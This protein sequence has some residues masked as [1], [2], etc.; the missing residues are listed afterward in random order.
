MKFNEAEDKVQNIK[1]K[2]YQKS[3]GYN[4]E[5]H[6]IAI[7]RYDNLSICMMAPGT[8]GDFKHL[9]TLVN[10]GVNQTSWCIRIYN[11]NNKWTAQIAPNSLANSIDINMSEILNKFKSEVDISSTLHTGII[12]SIDKNNV[13][14]TILKL[15]EIFRDKKLHIDNFEINKKFTLKNN[16]KI[17]KLEYSD[18]K[19]N[20][21]DTIKKYLNIYKTLKEKK[22]DDP[23]LNEMDITI[24]NVKSKETLL[25]LS[26][27]YLTEHERIDIAMKFILRNK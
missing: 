22:I 6:I 16:S 2:K 18:I 5:K 13:E 12:S 9:S 15:I 21:I 4:L 11:T 7:Y 10:D 26:K 20:D 3:K 8:K 14:K 23:L 17:F 27:K 25:E 19:V 1:P 24:L